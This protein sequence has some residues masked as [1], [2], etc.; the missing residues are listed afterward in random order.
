M[1]DVPGFFSSCASLRFFE[2]LHT[3]FSS[4]VEISSRYLDF[5]KYWAEA[6]GISLSRLS[7]KKKCL[8]PTR[9][10]FRPTI[11]GS[12]EIPQEEV[13][14][15]LTQFCGIRIPNFFAR[16]NILSKERQGH[17][18]GDHKECVSPEIVVPYHYFRPGLWDEKAMLV[19]EGFAPHVMRHSLF[20]VMRN[21]L[22]LV[23]YQHE[24][25]RVSAS[26]LIS[27]GQCSCLLCAKVFQRVEI[28]SLCC[29][30]VEPSECEVTKQRPIT[31][32]K[33]RERFLLDFFYVA[34][35]LI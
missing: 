27:K 9:N 31:W 21:R 30:V 18:R 26:H 4:M 32:I 13:F 7:Y 14:A 35:S 17:R 24:F 2:A 12:Q 23:C 1:N 28:D 22:K 29:I 20:F 25:A 11:S 33:W 15:R 34:Y 19:V 10:V 8:A 3:D 6:R 16:I 5:V